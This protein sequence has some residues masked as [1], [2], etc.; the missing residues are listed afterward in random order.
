VSVVGDLVAGAIGLLP[1]RGGGYLNKM[2]YGL[3]RPHNTAGGVCA[4]S[5]RLAGVA[6][7][8]TFA[9]SLQTRARRHRSDKRITARVRTW[10]C[11]VRRGQAGSGFELEDDVSTGESEAQRIDVSPKGGGMVPRGHTKGHR[12]ADVEHTGGVERATAAT[13]AKTSLTAP[14]KPT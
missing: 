11:G 5:I 2:S 6:Q 1:T 13:A 4:F 3:C 8:D 14:A 7:Y 9:A 10:R 12:K